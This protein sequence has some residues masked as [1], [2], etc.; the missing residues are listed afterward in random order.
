[1]HAR[2]KVRFSQKNIYVDHSTV[3]KMSEEVCGI[4]SGRLNLHML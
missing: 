4:Y 3:F 1:M 2:V